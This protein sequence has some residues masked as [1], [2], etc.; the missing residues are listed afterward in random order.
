MVA[1][2]SHT[3]FD[4]LDAYASSVF[5]GRV[6]GFVEAPDDPNEPGDE[7][8][9]IFSTDGT[10]GRLR[11]WLGGMDRVGRWTSSTLRAGRARSVRRW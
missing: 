9:M 1:L 11:R 2:I 8:C 7:Q 5:W 4:S 6:L 3:T 10:D